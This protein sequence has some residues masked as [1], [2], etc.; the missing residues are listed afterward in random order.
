MRPARDPA[1]ASRR[2][3][4]YERTL[5]KY[6]ALYKGLLI[7]QI[8]IAGGKALES[9]VK[10]QE[11]LLYQSIPQVGEVVNQQANQAIQIHVWQA[12]MQGSKY[13]DRN[14]PAKLRITMSFNAP[15]AQETLNRLNMDNQAEF[16]GLTDEMN[17]R[18]MHE[19][20]MGVQQGEGIEQIAK[21]IDGVADIGIKRARVIARDKTMES[22]NSGSLDRYILSGFAEVKRIETMDERTCTRPLRSP[23]WIAFGARGCMGING[24]IFKINEAPRENPHPDCRGGYV[25]VLPGAK[26]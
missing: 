10:R 18:V 19:I 8:N 3:L 14:T 13:A 24:L 5:L 2:I 11:N 21:R 15:A 9:P 17:K 20:V 4:E 16:K 12:Y 1:K 26:A 7:R 23:A 25:P 6:I 22:I